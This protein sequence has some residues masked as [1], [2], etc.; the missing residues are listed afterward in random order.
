[1]LLRLPGKGRHVLI[2]SIVS[3]YTDSHA[4]NKLLW[5]SQV[6]KCKKHNMQAQAI[7]WGVILFGKR[8]QRSWPA[9]GT[10]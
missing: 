3:Y 8:G 9:D 5:S 1:M 6:Q 2:S 10:G 4:G 7:Y